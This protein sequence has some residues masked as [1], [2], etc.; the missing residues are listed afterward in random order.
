MMDDDT[1]TIKGTAVKEMEEECGIV[2]DASELIDLSHLAFSSHKVGS[3]GVPM[4][5]GGC[6]ERMRLLYL[7]KSVTKAQLDQM[8]D[9]MTGLREE[10]EII[11]LRVVPYEDVWR[12]SADSKAIM[13]VGTCTFPLQ[14][15][16]TE[17]PDQPVPIN[18]I[19]W[20]FLLPHS[21]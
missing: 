8:R 6:D 17:Q 16:Q 13:Y 18:L 15:C 3:T 9:R 11:T 14:K 20:P 12:V 5:Q 2:I 1:Q 19:C 10:G 21:F 7:E 4:S